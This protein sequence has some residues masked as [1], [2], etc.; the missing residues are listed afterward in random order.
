MQIILVKITKKSL[1]RLLSDGVR[2]DVFLYYVLKF[3]WAERTVN[4]L[5]IWIVNGIYW[6][7]WIDADIT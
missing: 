1:G 7:A 5:A 4:F 2:P 6:R 3:T